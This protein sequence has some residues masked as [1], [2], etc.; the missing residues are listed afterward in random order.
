MQNDVPII[1]THDTFTRAMLSDKNVATDIFNS[2]LPADMLKITDLSNMELQPRSHIDVFGDE[3]ILDISYKAK[4]MGKDCY[5]TLLIEHQSKPLRLMPLKILRYSLNLLEQHLEAQK[6]K[7]GRNYKK[8][9]PL[10]YPIVIYHGKELYPYTKDIRDLVDAPRDLVERY[11]LQPFQLL[12]LGT[13]EDEQ[14]KKHVWSGIME[15]ALKYIY[16]NDFLSFLQNIVAECQKLEQLEGGKK[17]VGVML[18]Y[19]LSRGRLKSKEAFFE[20]VSKKFGQERGAEMMTLAE[21]LKA[22]GRAEAMTLAEQWKVEGRVEGRLKSKLEV[23]MNLIV[24]GLDLSF[25]AKVTGLPM[26]QLQDLVQSPV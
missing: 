2:Y 15:F 17:M 13:I 18:H 3:G 21:Q 1:Y 6:G 8:P 12:D 23:A 16:A 20:F 24:E 14:I 19:A 22:E 4:M 9:L 25:I 26:S 5:L 10:I 11:F 7:K